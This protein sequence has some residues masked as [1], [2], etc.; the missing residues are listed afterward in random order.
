[1]ELL[2]HEAVPSEKTW[3]KWSCSLISSYCSLQEMEAISTLFI[4]TL[5]F[6]LPTTAKQYRMTQFVLTQIVEP[7]LHYKPVHSTVE[8]I[9]PLRSAF[10]IPKTTNSKITCQF[11]WKMSKNTKFAKSRGSVAPPGSRS[12]IFSNCKMKEGLYILHQLYQIISTL[13]YNL[14]TMLPRVAPRAKLAFS[15]RLGLDSDIPTDWVIE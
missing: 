1:M 14:N 2:I 7:C 12:I 5:H 4:G 6:D 9:Q 8:L 13:L 10:E 11:F 3:I 15:D